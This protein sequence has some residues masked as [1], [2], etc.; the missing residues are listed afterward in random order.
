[1]R[2]QIP[3]VGGMQERFA[4]TFDIYL[5]ILRRADK[6]ANRELGRDTPGWRAIHGCAACTKKVLVPA[7]RRKRWADVIQGDPCPLKLR[8]LHCM[9]GG[10]S[11]KR[12]ADAGTAD[13]R[14]Y[15]PE[16]FLSRS[17]VDNYSD[18]VQH[19]PSA[20]KRKGKGGKAAKKTPS[21]SR[22]ADEQ[23]S[24]ADADEDDELAEGAVSVDDLVDRVG[25]EARCASTWK[26]ANGRESTTEGCEQTGLFA[27]L[28][29]HGITECLVEMVRSGE[30]CV[31]YSS[32]VAHC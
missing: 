8:R 24:D 23:A 20:P 1:M 9:D 25:T 10:N 15:E 6:L 32:T 27:M 2:S 17:F 5:E 14:T 29:R 18:E 11:Y 22:V 4:R 26:A 7:S 16:I 30:L 19:R 12:R 31:L 13:M 21:S 28:C 3:Y